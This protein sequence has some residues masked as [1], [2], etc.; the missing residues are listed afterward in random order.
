MAHTGPEMSS[1]APSRRRGRAAPEAA[2]AALSAIAAGEV[3][4]CLTDGVDRSECSAI[5]VRSGGQGELQ[6]EVA[7][8]GSAGQVVRL[9]SSGTE[10]I[11][12]END[13]AVEVRGFTRSTL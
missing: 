9:S 1:G 11:L 10:P 7:V 5:H 2:D 4:S 3:K 8:E 12:E 6:C 13:S